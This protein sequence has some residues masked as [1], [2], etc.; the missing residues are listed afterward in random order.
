[1]L[2]VWAGV[3]LGLLTLCLLWWTRRPREDNNE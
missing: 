3:Y 2:W 1:M